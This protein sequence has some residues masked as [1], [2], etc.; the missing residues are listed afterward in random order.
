MIKKH[1]FSINLASFQNGAIGFIKISFFMA[2]TTRL[3]SIDK[4]EPIHMSSRSIGSF[5][6][7]SGRASVRVCVGV[8][9]CVCVIMLNLILFKN[10]CYLNHSETPLWRLGKRGLL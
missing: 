9:V 5:L 6:R 1:L 7:D 3:D 8:R 2:F 10:V 4:E